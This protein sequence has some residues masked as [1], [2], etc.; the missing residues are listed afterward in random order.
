MKKQLIITLILSMILGLSTNVMANMI[1]RVENG[2]FESPDNE[3]LGWLT[4]S[5]IPGWSVE[6][7]E[8]GDPGTLEI[9]DNGVVVN[10][11]DG[12]Q[13]AE[14]DT[15]AKNATCPNGSCN[16]SIY[17]DIA[18]CPGGQYSISYAWRPR[19][20]HEGSCKL[21]LYWDGNL[22]ATH[23][24][25]SSTSWYSENINMGASGSSARLKFKE[26]GTGDT[27]GTFLD[28]V[29]VVENYCPII[30]VDLDIKPNS[31]PNCFNV[32]GH[33]VIPVAILGSADFDVTVVDI[34]SLSFAGLEVRVRGNG[35]PQCSIEDISGD[36]Y[37]DLVCQ[38]VDDPDYWKP[39]DG[40]AEITGVTIDG[41]PIKGT[42]SICV[43]QE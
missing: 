9:Q 10:A 43:T 38:F 8:N 6:W 33:G 15:G 20:E 35:N 41:I 23:E 29:S 40:T 27:L 2:S 13:Y 39:T 24:S 22:I 18:T 25:S 17:Q 1:E 42:D 16:V 37:D 19:P 3:G 30:E 34:A 5:D 32:N 36:G 12:F 26:I 11:V 28:D 14:M 4:S 21:E 7:V 31:F